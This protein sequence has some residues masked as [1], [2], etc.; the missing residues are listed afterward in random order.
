MKQIA[1]AAMVAAAF[2]TFQAPAQAENEW[3]NPCTWMGGG[4]NPCAAKNPC[5]PK[6]PCNPC[7]MKNPCSPANPCNPCAMKAKKSN[8]AAKV[9]PASVDPAKVNVSQLRALP[10]KDFNTVAE[11]GMK[12]GQFLMGG[13]PIAGTSRTVVGELVDLS[14]YTG[15]GYTSGSH[16]LCARVCALK[17]APVGLRLDDGT[18]F[19]VVPAQAGMPLEDDVLDAVATKI[20]A[21]GNVN[22]RGGLKTISITKVEQL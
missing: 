17:G 12:T 20:R 4:K 16:A 5:S 22:D 1:L 11:R 18:V 13:Q 7:A 6:N 8:P 19:Q 9:N 10:D 3:L 21:T 2:L 14:C 15:Y